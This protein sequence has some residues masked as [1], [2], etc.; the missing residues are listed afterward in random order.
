MWLLKRDYL[1]LT[2]LGGFAATALLLLISQQPQRLIQRR[3][4]PAS[5]TALWDARLA[6][7][8]RIDLNSA[9][10]SELA[11]LPGVGPALA[12]RIVQYR[13]AHGPFVTVED[14]A[15]VQGIGSTLIARVKDDVT[16]SS[17]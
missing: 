12:E 5:S 6:T 7:A 16:C 9:G 17:R 15:Q 14:L 4:P 3:E 13:Q 11:R 2:A 8:R 1:M 10:A